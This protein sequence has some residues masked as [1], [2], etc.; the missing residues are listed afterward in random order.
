MSDKRSKKYETKVA[1]DISGGFVQP[2]SGALPYW[3]HDVRGDYW[4]VEHKYTEAK[5]FSIK[6]NYFEEVLKNAFK[7]DKLPVMIVEFPNKPELKL[8]VIRYADF[9]EFDKYLAREDNDSK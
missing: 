8:A 3:K 1:K 9:L 4:L 6:K 7:D 5:S 2:A